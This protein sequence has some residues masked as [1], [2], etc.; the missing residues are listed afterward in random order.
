M[1]LER[2]LSAKAITLVLLASALPLAAQAD[3]TTVFADDVETGPAGW[4]GTGLWHRATL[5]SSSPVTAWYYGIENANG[6][7][8]TYDTGAPNAGELVSPL[9]DLA[10]LPRARLSFWSHWQGEGTC[11]WEHPIVQVLRANGTRANVFESCAPSGSGTFEANLTAF[12][13]GPVRLVFRWD[14]IDTG[15]NQFEGWHIDDVIVDDVVVTAPPPPAPDLLIERV[16]TSSPTVQGEKLHVSVT[17]RNNGTANV[18][19]PF[20]LEYRIDGG[21][22]A[23]QG[24][25]PMMPASFSFTTT[26]DLNATGV[27]AH[28]L[29]VM[30]D[31]DGN[32]TESNEDNNVAAVGFE[33]IKRPEVGIDIVEIHRVPLRTEFGDLRHPLARHEATIVVCNVGEVASKNGTLSLAVS[34]GNGNQTTSGF[35]GGGSAALPAE[36]VPALAAGGCATIEVRFD[37]PGVVGDFRLHA[38]LFVPHDGPARNSDS[39]SSYNLVADEGGIVAPGGAR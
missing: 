4:N 34:G 24:F 27:G 22:A 39:I 5:R 37:T 10:G 28:V 14:T 11:V 6:T 17:F 9:I 33:T 36:A 3:A 16:N 1:R 29:E 20:V 21:L 8:G 19:P 26:I 23:R 13:G 32:V 30:I 35:S 25:P 12:V 2:T 15:A 31:A 38:S 18:T 7:G